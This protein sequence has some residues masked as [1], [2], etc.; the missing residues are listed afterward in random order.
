MTIPDSGKTEA[1]AALHTPG[2]PLIL[3]TVRD[4]GSAVAVAKPEAK[5][6]ATFHS[7]DK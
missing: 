4:A 3:H 6:R 1:F 2:H 7:L 5:V